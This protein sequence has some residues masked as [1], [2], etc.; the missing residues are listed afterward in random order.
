M[1]YAEIVLARG[2]RVQGYLLYENGAA[3]EG[4]QVVILPQEYPSS[5]VEPAI[6]SDRGYFEALHV[7]AGENTI[8][9]RAEGS[10][11]FTELA[12]VAI[13]TQQQLELYL[14]GAGRAPTVEPNEQ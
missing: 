2:H 13:P 12:S 6:C 10:G 1:E 11:Q 3:A 4:G 14:E 5:L 7:P 9:A 8:R